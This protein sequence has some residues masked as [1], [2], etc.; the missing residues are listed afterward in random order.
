MQQGDNTTLPDSLRARLWVPARYYVPRAEGRSCW[1]WLL[2]ED[3]RVQAL[4]AEHVILHND[5]N[6]PAVLEWLDASLISRECNDYKAGLLRE[7]PAAAVVPTPDPTVSWGHPFQHALRAFVH[8]LDASILKT[9]G[10]LEGAGPYLSTISNYNRFAEL[11]ASTRHYRLQALAE[12]PP[13][14]APLMLDVQELPDHYAMHGYEPTL[15]WDPGT[16]AGK[17]V[18][19]AIDE[20]RELIDPLAR[21]H[22]IDRALVRSPLCREPWPD[23]HAPRPLLQVLNA[24]PARARP[25]NLEALES[26]RR[27]LD[28]LPLKIESPQDAERLARSFRKTWTDTWD[29]LQQ[30]YLALLSNL[31]DAGDF[32]HSALQQMPPDPDLDWL[33]KS[34][35]TLAWLAR[36]G[37]DSLLEASR[38][39]H[40]QPAEPF[41]A[42][43]ELPQDIPAIFE[44]ILLEGVRAR[45]LTSARALHQEGTQHEPLR[46]QLLDRLRPARHAHRAPGFHR[47]RTRHRRIQAQPRLGRVQ[48][49]TGPAARPRQHRTQPGHARPCRRRAADDQLAC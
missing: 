43:T 26:G 34:K 33:D 31:A 35:L 1:L 37:L 47:G 44:E 13:L 4:Q 42:D 8:Q 10:A 25:D 49:Q 7:L 32:I 45:E 41:V 14:V 40:A 39:W 36:R 17:A 19:A 27:F 20:G 12:F 22:G 15:R 6:L 2:R 46:R 9:L 18:L 29:G 16:D 11:P 24:I 38:R 48:I 5:N 30:N 21:F 3:G 23:G 28:A